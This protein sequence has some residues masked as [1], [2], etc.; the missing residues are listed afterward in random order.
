MVEMRMR[1]KYM[2]DALEFDERQVAQSGAG[3]DQD[4]VIDA[5][6]GGPRVTTDAATATKHFNSH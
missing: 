2:I 5:Q 1:K 3:I 4:V 6:A